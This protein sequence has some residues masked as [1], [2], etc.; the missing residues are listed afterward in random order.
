M[1]ASTII[2]N[3]MGKKMGDFLSGGV[4]DLNPI[5][6]SRGNGAKKNDFVGNAKSIRDLVVSKKGMSLSDF[7]AG[8]RV[9][10]SVNK[11]GKTS[12]GQFIDEE[13]DA[14]RATA[15]AMAASTVAAYGVAP[16]MFGEDNVI[17]RTIEGGA[18]MGMHAGITSSLIRT[19]GSGA[20]FGVGYAGLAAIN[21]IRQGDNFGPF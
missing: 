20:M 18:A 1:A 10:A 3:Y 12:F 17:N 8:K 16:M 6:L 2:H 19:G 21:A 4:G 14:A 7:F 5:S 13:N 15:R 9:Q 11:G